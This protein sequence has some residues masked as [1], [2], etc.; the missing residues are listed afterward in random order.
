MG[1]GETP[2]GLRD[3]RALFLRGDRGRRI[4]LAS[5]RDDIEK[6]GGELGLHARAETADACERCRVT[7]RMLRD[8]T[9]GPLGEELDPRDPQ[10]RSRARAP[11]E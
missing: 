5:S 8:G 2:V 9:D 10:R 4:L 3:C 6:R 11:L 7:R 1:S